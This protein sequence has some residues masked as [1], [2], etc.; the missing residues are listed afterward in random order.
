[1]AGEGRMLEARP[2][3]SVQCGRR[4]CASAGSWPSSVRSSCSRAA[5]AVPPGEEAAGAALSEEW[6]PLGTTFTT[7]RPQAELYVAGL[8]I[9]NASEHLFDDLSNDWAPIPF[10]AKAD[11][12]WVNSPLES[13]V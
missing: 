3:S 11:P 13:G 12:A 5:R 8:V 4:S 10:P 9:G 2:S 1:M 7:F 6:H